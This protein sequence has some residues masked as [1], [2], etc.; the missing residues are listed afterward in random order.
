MRLFIAVRFDA[1]TQAHILDVQGRL[2]NLDQH[3]SFT[4]LENLHLT[5][6]FL[7]EVRPERL[8]AVKQAMLRTHIEPMDL[9]FDRV[10]RFRQRDS[11]LWWIGLR[12]NPTLE[13]IQ[14]ELSRHLA[15]ENFPLETRAFQPHLTLARRVLLP[16]KP[17]RAALLG[18]PF[19]TH[20]KQISLMESSRLKG[21]LVYTERFVVAG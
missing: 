17:D 13:R 19:S 3:A 2:W 7:G 16:R 10:G 4:R 20:V 21:K 11:E 1:E 5:L 8:N 14:G 12:L 6:V 18:D 15:A 9:T